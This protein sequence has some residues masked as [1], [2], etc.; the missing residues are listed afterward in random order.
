MALEIEMQFQAFSHF[1]RTVVR[2]LSIVRKLCVDKDLPL[3]LLC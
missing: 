1:A 2:R 3:N